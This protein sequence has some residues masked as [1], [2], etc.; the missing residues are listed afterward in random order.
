[1]TRT[2]CEPIALEGVGLHGGIPARL[3]IRPARR[4]TGILFQRSDIPG[5]IGLIPARHDR[6]V[7]T[8]LC[9]RI[10]NEH[11]A[12]IAT[13][14]HLMAALAACGVSDAVVRVDGPEVP[15]LDGSAAPVVEAI[16]ETGLTRPA[17]PRRAIAIRRTVR[18]EDASRMAALHPAPRFSARFRIEFDD[19]AIGT[20]SLSLALA[21]EAAVEALADC[22]TFARRA[23]IEMLHR[24][25]LARGGS[26]D[27]AVVVDGARV[28]N[29]GGLRRPDEFVRHKILDAVGDLALAGAP[30][31]G[32]Y[33]GLRAGH[34]MTS[35][36]LHAL[37]DQPD[38]WEWVDAAPGQLP[39]LGR[40]ALPARRAAAEARLAV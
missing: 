24:A 19:P 21:G 2:I 14:E 39:S 18:V 29:P 6:V 26:L 7:D 27:N 28:L 35:R 8:R 33:E 11:G 32:Q 30:I 23:E 17:G 31:I 12:S 38:A 3:E 37:F 10:A 13:I 25:G 9:T 15:I 5:P 4:G 34:E 20:Q 1:M 40:T 36:L 22:R 16:R